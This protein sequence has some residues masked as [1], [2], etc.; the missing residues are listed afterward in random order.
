MARGEPLAVRQCIAN[1]GHVCLSIAEKTIDDLLSGLGIEHQR[2][3][4]YPNSN[5]RFDFVIGDLY[6]EYFGLIGDADYEARVKAKIA[7]CKMLGIKLLPVYPKDLLDVEKLTLKM[8]RM[9]L[10]AGGEF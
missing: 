5:H 6:I 10:Q 8:K 2:E 4:P 3:V 9:Q 1:D 7:S